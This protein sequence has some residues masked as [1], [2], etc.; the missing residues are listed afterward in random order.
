MYPEGRNHE[1]IARLEVPVTPEHVGPLTISA[2]Y[3]ALGS[4]LRRDSETVYVQS[5][6]QLH[7][8]IDPDQAVYAP[9]DEAVL[10]VRVTDAQG[11][12]RAA[13][14]GLQGVDEAVYSLMEFRPG[15]ENTY[16]RIP[17]P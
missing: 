2:Y 13:A 14:V 5:A 16:F 1:G 3:L 6:D 15:L 11:E 17:E 10:N 7:I 8:E 4:D 9:G 12:G